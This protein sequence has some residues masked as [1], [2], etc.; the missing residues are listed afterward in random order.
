[1]PLT[2]GDALTYLGGIG[3]KLIRG[4]LLAGIVI[5]ML[6]YISAED[7][8]QLYLLPPPH[9]IHNPHITLNNLHHLRAAI[10]ID[11]IRYWDALG[12]VAA[13]L[14]CGVN[15]LEQGSGIDTRDN[16]VGLVYGLGT[17]SAGADADG[18]ERMSHRS[19]E[20]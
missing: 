11:L 13:E 7:D 4:R 6:H 14:D 20:G 15:S 8:N 10:L 17:L 9:L 18:R 12:A 5:I 2:N 19:E 16:E 1:M 3:R